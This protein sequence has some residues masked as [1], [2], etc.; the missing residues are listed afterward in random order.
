MAERDEAKLR[1]KLYKKLYYIRRTVLDKKTIK[2]LKEMIEERSCGK[3]GKMFRSQFVKA[4][5]MLDA[6]MPEG[7]P[8][9]PR[10]SDSSSQN[11]FHLGLRLTWIS[12]LNSFWNPK[13]FG[14]QKSVD[15]LEL[16][17]SLPVLI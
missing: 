11:T 3:C 6:H 8:P 2:E 1:G 14:M 17:P 15:L 13:S 16:N 10:N 9:T 5:H 7:P 4:C 12:G